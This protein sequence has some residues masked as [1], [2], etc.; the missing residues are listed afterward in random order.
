MTAA[1]SPRRACGVLQPSYIP[2]LGYFDQI[3]SVDDFVLLDNVQYD[4]HGWRNRNRILVQGS[5][6]WL[7]VPIVRE[8]GQRLD[9]AR[10]A[11][12]RDWQS[13][14]LKTISQAY[15]GTTGVGRVTDILAHVLA[16][17]YERLVDINVALTLAFLH[18]LGINT[19]IHLSS[20]LAV[21]GEST[22]RLVNTC[23][24]LGADEYIS[25]PSARDYLDEGLFAESLISVRWH[26]YADLV[27]KQR[28]LAFVPRLSIVD[29]ACM[30]GVDNVYTLLPG[31]NDT[32]R[33]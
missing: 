1:H 16:N 28:S 6:T 19:R 10:V 3:A 24:R 13:R 17:G 30:L 11:G 27:Y 26:H 12:G 7:T 31:H 5:I 29:A 22:A 14:H 18:D 21:D 25:G 15:A 2:W 8:Y 20:D 32:A 4:K 9:E 23:K 33:F